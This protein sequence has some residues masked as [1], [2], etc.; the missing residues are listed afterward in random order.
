[1]TN[2][3]AVHAPM[4]RPPI[5]VL[6][7]S[8]VKSGTPPPRTVRCSTCHVRR[9]ERRMAAYYPAGSDQR[10]WACEHPLCREDARRMI[11]GE[12]VPS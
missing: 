6:T 9:V 1:M 11:R 10:H 12:A 5:G 3:L 7:L 8:L 4:T 2:D